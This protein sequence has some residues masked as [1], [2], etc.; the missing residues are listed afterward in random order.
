MQPIT[1]REPESH[2]SKWICRIEH[3]F[4]EKKAFPLTIL[5]ANTSPPINVS[6]SDRSACHNLIGESAD[7]VNFALR[8]YSNGRDNGFRAWCGGLNVQCLEIDSKRA[9]ELDQPLASQ[10]AA[11]T[12]VVLRNVQGLHRFRQQLL[13]CAAEISA[14]PQTAEQLAAFYATGTTP[15]VATLHALVLAIKMAR[16]QRFLSECLA[17]LVREMQ[18]SPAVLLDGGVNRL[19][20]SKEIIEETRKH[21]H[22]FV[23]TDYRRLRPDGTPEIFMPGPSNIH[24][25]FDRPHRV[26][27]CNFWAPMHDS[28]ETEIVQVYPDVYRRPIHN[29]E[30]SADNRRLLGDP[31][32]V[33]LRFG[34]A[35][36]FHGEHLHHSPDSVRRRHS[37]DLRIASRAMDDNRH[38][39]DNFSHS[40][41]FVRAVPA[42]PELRP[43]QLLPTDAVAHHRRHGP[44]HTANFYQVC[45]E[46]SAALS[47]RSAKQLFQVFRQYPF[48]EDRFLLLAD[49]AKDASGKLAVQILNYV[50]ERTH[51]YY[52]HLTCARRLRAWGESALARRAYSR[53]I[54]SARHSDPLPD[55]APVEYTNPLSQLLPAEA[56]RQAQDELDELTVAMPRLGLVG[57]LKRWT[58]WNRVRSRRAA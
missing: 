31:V 41:N 8:G 21:T 16:D 20:L 38:Y 23:P 42:E 57:M 1:S 4:V 43:C 48:A 13:K 11:G 3:E 29:H 58:G 19:V 5:S 56:A 32:R 12:V 49:R 30:N 55:L 14:D 53:A 51:S 7:I 9:G 35:L 6:L 44:S 45:L 52:Y 34:D 39:R 36:L 50:V 37:Y 46:N 28:D 10:L 40:N 2:L 18:F 26:L 25:D 22:L 27:M 47:A 54:E 17:D 24:R 33:P 15:P